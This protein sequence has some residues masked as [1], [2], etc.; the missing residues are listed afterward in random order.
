[1]RTPWRHT[2]LFLEAGEVW[3]F[4]YGVLLLEELPE[5]RRHGLE[6]LH[7]SLEESLTRRF[8]PGR[9]ESSDFV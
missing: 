3:Q 2:A 1:M 7:Q 9:A 8:S 6:D 4:Y 5:C